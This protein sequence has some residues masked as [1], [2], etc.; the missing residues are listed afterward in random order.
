[1]FEV[2]TYDY[3]AGQWRTVGK[4]DAAAEDNAW[5]AYR[6]RSNAGPALLLKDGER[7][8]GFQNPD[9]YYTRGF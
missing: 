3:D 9:H 6:V 2:Q 4:F 1:M 5:F 8:A 7:L